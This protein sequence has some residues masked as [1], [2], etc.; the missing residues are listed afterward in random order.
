MTNTSANTYDTVLYPGF[1]LAQAHPD[2]LATQ[3]ALFGM[4]PADVAHCRV[5]ELGCGDGM[6]LISVALGLPEAECVGVDLAA[7][8]IDKGRT[9]IHE[10]GLKNITLRQLN[11]M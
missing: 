4:T 7:A 6:N 3:A 8:G 10:L 1:A 2:R 11:L 9:V 5:L